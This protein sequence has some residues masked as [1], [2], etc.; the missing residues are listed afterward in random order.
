MVMGQQRDSAVQATFRQL[1]TLT[2]AVALAAGVAFR[3]VSSSNSSGLPDRV[4]MILVVCLLAW[5]LAT[6]R[7]HYL[8]YVLLL[9]LPFYTYFRRMYTPTAWRAFRH[10]AA[11]SWIR[12]CFCQTRSC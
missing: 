8:I 2:V 12:C 11:R 4:A 6:C 10:T 3:I 7:R 9:V 5:A 1:L